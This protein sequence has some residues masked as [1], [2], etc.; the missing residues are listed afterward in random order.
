MRI[1]KASDGSLNA[2][3]KA[4]MKRARIWGSGTCGSIATSA[5]RVTGGGRGPGW[6]ARCPIAAFAHETAGSLK[7]ERSRF[8]SVHALST[9]AL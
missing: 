1:S 4:I 2:I 9:C 3:A 8:K 5:F 6:G 7:A